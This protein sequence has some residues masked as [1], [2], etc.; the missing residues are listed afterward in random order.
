MQTVRPFGSA[1]GRAKA[2]PFLGPERDAA[3]QAQ[4]GRADVNE[5]ESLRSDP[6]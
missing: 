2:G 1:V 6:T 4:Q 3:P 5:R